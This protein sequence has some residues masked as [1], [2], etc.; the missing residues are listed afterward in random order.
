MAVDAL[1]QISRARSNSGSTLK[2]HFSNEDSSQGVLASI[3]NI[4]GAAQ[5]NLSIHDDTYS[6]EN[7][8]FA[9]S[10]LLGSGIVDGDLVEI[11]QVNKAIEVRDFEAQPSAGGTFAFKNRAGGNEPSAIAPPTFLCLVKTV[12][13]EQASK[14][15]NFELSVNKQIALAFDFSSPSRAVI[16]RADKQ[17]WRSSHAEICFRDAYLSRADMWRFTTQELVGKTI[18]AGQKLS[19]LHSLKA[20][21]RS[22]HVDGRHARVAYFDSTTVPVFRSEAA[23]YVIFIQMSREMWDFDSDGNGEILFNRVVN[24]FLPELFKRWS[25]MEVR[26]LVSIVMFGRLEY[27]RS[28]IIEG[29]GV[30]SVGLATQSPSSAD[31]R[32]IDHQDFYRV[33]VTDMASAQWTTILDELKRDFRTFLRDVLLF[34]TPDTSS[35]PTVHEDQEG[36]PSRITGRLSGALQGNILEAINLAASQFSDDYIDRDLIRTGISTVV[37]TAGSGVFDVDRDLLKLTSET[38]TNNGIGIDIVCLSRMPL[39]SVP[40]FRY[41]LEEGKDTNSVDGIRGSL[42]PTSLSQ[43]LPH[44]SL[45]NMSASAAF[46]STNTSLNYFSRFPSAFPTRLPPMYGYGIP[47]WIDLSYWSSEIEHEDSKWRRRRSKHQRDNFMS[48]NLFKPRVRMYELQMM[49][50]MEMGMADIAIPY[51]NEQPLES[52]A[53][54]QKWDSRLSRSQYSR[55]LSRSPEMQRKA[56]ASMHTFGDLRS[57]QVASS[58]ADTALTRMD[59]YDKSVFITAAAGPTQSGRSKDTQKLQNRSDTSNLRLKKT[60]ASE[61]TTRSAKASPKSTS[62]ASATSKPGSNVSDFSRS[63]RPARAPRILSYGAKGLMP[64]KPTAVA[65]QVQAENINAQTTTP[66]TV[67]ESSDES[68]SKL[69]SRPAILSRA[70][71]LNLGSKHDGLSRPS[72]PNKGDEGSRPIKIDANVNAASN[73]DSSTKQLWDHRRRRRIR[74]ERNDN[75]EQVSDS[76]DKLSDISATPESIPNSVPESKIPFVRNVNA[77][78][79]LKRKSHGAVFGRWQHLY[80]RRPRAATVKWRSLCTPASVPLTT[81]DFPSREELERNY[82]ALCH[83]VRSQTS[84]AAVESTKNDM[85]S[86]FIELLS[87]RIS[88]GYQF[89]VG[90]N[91]SAALEEDL[92]NCHG[93]CQPGADGQSR[94]VAVLAMGN[95]IQKLELHKGSPVRVTKYVQKQ[96]LKS[97]SF[98]LTFH[99]DPYIL[100]ILSDNYFSRHLTFQGFSEQYPWDLADNHVAGHGQDDKQGTAVEQLR[101]WRARFV[102]LPVEPP[103]STWKKHQQDENEEEIHI[104]GIRALTQLWQKN[105]YVTARDRELMQIRMGNSKNRDENPLEVRMETLNP[106]Q[107]VALELDRLAQFEDGGESEST[108]LLPEPQK[109]DRETSMSKIAQMMQS[110]QGIEIKHRRWHWRLYHN[111][112]HGEEFTNW[113]MHN[114][115]NMNTRE[116]AVE[117]GNQLM[118]EGL[119]EHVNGRHDFKDGTYFYSIKQQYRQFRP[120]LTRSWFSTIKSDK[121]VPPTPLAEQPPKELSPYTVRTR[122]GSNIAQQ[123]NAASTPESKPFADKRRKAVSLSRMIRIDVDTRKKSFLGRPEMVHVHYDRFYN[124][125]NCYHIELNWFNTTC[126]LVDDAIVSWTNVAEKYGLKLVEVPIAEACDVPIAEPFRNPHTIKL[127]LEPPKQKANNVLFNPIFYSNTSFTPH[128]PANPFNIEKHVY[129]KAILKRS[130]FVLD[131]EAAN[132]F[133]EGV[134]IQYSWGQFQYKYTQFVHRSGVLLAQI[135]ENGDIIV[136][137]NRLYNSRL[138]NTKENRMFDP[139]G[140]SGPQS[141]RPAIPPT[142]AAS[143]QA[144]GIVGINLASPTAPGTSSPGLHPVPNM[145]ALASPNPSARPPTPSRAPT[146]NPTP[147]AGKTIIADSF[148]PKST[149]I[150]TGLWNTLITPEQIKDDLEAFC[151]DKARLEAFYKEVA[152][153]PTPQIGG[154]GGGSRK[155]TGSSSSSMLRPVREVPGTLASDITGIPAFELPEAVTAVRELRRATVAYEN[156]GEMFDRSR[157]NSRHGSAGSGEI[158]EGGRAGNGFLGTASPLRKATK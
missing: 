110:D 33:V 51:L 32:P 82:D 4:K 22:I 87:L 104:L 96:D 114:V 133:P 123:L 28:D 11:K 60:K 137:A 120:D 95:T 54:L 146:S 58:S 119:F 64:L 56:P 157:M 40:L 50:L 115:K 156:V 15:H 121:S 30:L 18:H 31:R 81:A 140:N 78:N 24:G 6:R 79:P 9:E 138:A 74:S 155:A 151:Q 105:R 77:S 116:D 85:R 14:Q 7:V 131:L 125:E 45:P 44:V 36:Q 129:Q 141:H 99:Y 10:C 144:S 109:L 2:A 75:D 20:T 67:D 117:F 139:K 35:Q 13:S 72:T 147:D 86:L 92:S 26:H 47:Q 93:I 73:M 63:S 126:K 57:P 3:D 142:A 80:P 84:D 150:A 130:N 27:R 127:A 132:E 66:A 65:A 29:Q 88:H 158:D 17:Q 46:S 106:S 136:L 111:C 69:T 101:Y 152:N 149:F 134:D 1:T 135:M 108:Q 100:T 16:G 71:M 68:R 62:M 8:L 12:P 97:I 124:P 103:A 53:S 21:V 59:E 23:R 89:V 153:A 128:P 102:L 112:F 148:G 90:N 52:G 83:V 145:G 5:V 94:L 37:I 91:V 34:K 43:S 98:N 39:H 42:S 107:M 70:S 38:L 55:S 122:S 113:L 154:H 118:K 19:F 61:I 48:D 76:D 49:G 25:N 143:M 41:R